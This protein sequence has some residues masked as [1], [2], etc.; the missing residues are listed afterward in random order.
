MG[1]GGGELTVGPSAAERP[2]HVLH[3]A[4]NSPI[5]ASACVSYRLTDLLVARDTAT[6]S[7]DSWP[8]SWGGVASTGSMRRIMAR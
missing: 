3:V 4:S 8:H 2:S 5:R 1:G 7:S 6:L